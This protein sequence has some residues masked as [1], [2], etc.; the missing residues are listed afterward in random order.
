MRKKRFDKYV[1]IMIKT[2]TFD[3]LVEV[4]DKHEITLSKY[5]RQLI[6]DRLKKEVEE[7]TNDG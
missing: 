2:E 5:I 4:T 7:K 6:K 3:Q 1:G